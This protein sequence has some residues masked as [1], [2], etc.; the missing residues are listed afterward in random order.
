M[1]NDLTFKVQL[2]AGGK[3]FGSKKTVPGFSS[4]LQT[5]YNTLKHEKIFSQMIYIAID[6]IFQKE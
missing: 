3:V 6:E 2:P 4:I 5:L 1:E